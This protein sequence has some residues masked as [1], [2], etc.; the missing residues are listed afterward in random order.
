MSDFLSALPVLLI[1]LVLFILYLRNIYKLY[2][3]ISAQQY[4]FITGLRVFG[5][6]FFILGIV[7]GFVK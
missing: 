6:F 7:M 5:V 1:A 4:S 3:D 2:R